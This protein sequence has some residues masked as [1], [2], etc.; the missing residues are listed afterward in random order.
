MSTSTAARYMNFCGDETVCEAV[1]VVSQTNGSSDA[2]IEMSQFAINN[3]S[4]WL[5]HFLNREL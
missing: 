2:G 4:L 1:D 3:T 5:K